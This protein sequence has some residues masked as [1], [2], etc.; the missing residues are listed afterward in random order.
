[1]RAVDA[2]GQ[3]ARA[4]LVTNRD[5]VDLAVG[6]DHYVHSAAATRA[7]SRVGAGGSLTGTVPR[8][9]RDSEECIPYFG[10]AIIPMHP[11]SC[12]ERHCL[13]SLCSREETV[14]NFVGAP[15]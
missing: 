4:E 2:V 7:V 13:E 3:V 5:T 9:R 11:P 14:N 1:M 12:A 10:N 8:G 6:A 15:A